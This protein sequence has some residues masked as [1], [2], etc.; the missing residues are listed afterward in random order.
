[1]EEEIKELRKENGELKEKL[2]MIEM[3]YGE[4]SILKRLK[5]Y[6]KYYKEKKKNANNRNNTKN[7]T[8][9]N[10]T[11]CNNSNGNTRNNEINS[12]F[13]DKKIEKEK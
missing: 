4:N 7:D 6:I 11:I 12:L 2:E 13:N 3:F 10:N 1:M 5:F 8:A 9:R